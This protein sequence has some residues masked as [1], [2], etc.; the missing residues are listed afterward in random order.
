MKKA[1][2]IGAGI[3]GLSIAAR[4]LHKG[5]KVEIY[6]KNSL[7]GGQTSRLTFDKFNFDLTASILM[8]PKD[9]I[10]VFTYCNKNYKDYFT[11]TEL[12]THYRVFYN[13]G[14]SYDF[15]SNIC[16]LT[17]TI[18]KITSTDIISNHGF[19]KFLASNYKKFLYC[20]KYFLNQS[21]YNK[22]NFFTPLKISKLLSIY[23]F[24]SCYSDCKKYISNEKLINY[25]MFQS[26]YIGSSPYSS[27][28]I[29]NLVPAVTQY[30]GLYYIKGGIYS[31]IKALEKLVYDLGGI[32]KTSTPVEKILFNKDTAIGIKVND[33]SI[34]SDLVIC[35]CDY[36]YS[37]CN[38]I[39]S[40]KLSNNSKVIK[41][42]EYSCSTFILYLA[43]DKKYPTLNIHNIYINNKNFKT[44]LEAPFKGKFPANPSLY[45]YCPSSIDS[46]LCPSNCETINIILRVPNLISNKIIWDRHTINKVENKILNILCGINGLEDIKSHIIHKEVL[47]PNN[48]KE[49]FNNSNGCAFGLSHSL[50][51]SLIFR[52][53]YKLPKLKGIY[54]T[55]SSIHPGNGISMVL[56]S[57]RICADNIDL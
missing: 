3:S 33:K 42:F 48:F 49:D 56:K 41:K 46:S 13:D 8:I 10:E 6:E 16:E 12:P 55:G 20:E 37:I 34:Y 29:Y 39:P 19:F 9:Y 24:K 40:N 57:S 38:L 4:L 43:L 17:K 54:F 15:S 30:R 31:Y 26:M 25:C 27:S 1:I 7:V 14:T 35:S 36:S 52:P 51:Q 21:F 32:I 23:P 2:I 44:N 50:N 18:E 5:F 45:I 53:Q 22:F 47:T 11:L 28:N